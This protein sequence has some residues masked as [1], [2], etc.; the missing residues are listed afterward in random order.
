MPFNP[1]LFN[2]K[3]RIPSAR[4]EWW[5]YFEGIYF[6]TIM[7]KNRRYYFGKITHNPQT[8]Q[9]EMHFSK[10][11]EY[12]HE[13]ISKISDHQW[14][15]YVPVWTV[16]PNHI[17]LIALIDN[18]GR[19][20]ANITATDGI[21]SADDGGND[22]DSMPKYERDVRSHVS[23]DTNPVIAETTGPNPVIAQTTDIALPIHNVSDQNPLIAQTLANSGAPS[24]DRRT[25]EFMASIAPKTGSLALVIGHLKRAVTKYAHDKNIESAW[26]PRYHDEILKDQRA[27]DAVRRYIDNNVA[28]W[29]TDHLHL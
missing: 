28:K 2:E 1:I 19:N 12:V 5:E 24:G 17:H 23:T 26:Q 29:H 10:L 6:V 21:C 8:R 27:F 22:G 9:N 20:N 18:R 25:P 4:A 7:T 3:Y 11:G 15:A 14:Y 16:M 13:T